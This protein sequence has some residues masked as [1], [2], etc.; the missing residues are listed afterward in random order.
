MQLLFGV[1]LDTPYQAYWTTVISC[2]KYQYYCKSLYISISTH[3]IYENK[4]VSYL[5]ILPY[6][7]IKK[8]YFQRTPYYYTLSSNS[9]QCTYTHSLIS[10]FEVSLFPIS[11]LTFFLRI[12]CLFIYLFIVIPDLLI[13]YLLIYLLFSQL[14]IRLFIFIFFYFFFIYF[15]FGDLIHD[16]ETET[17][18]WQANVSKVPEEVQELTRD[19]G[20][21]VVYRHISSTTHHPLRGLWLLYGGAKV[22]MEIKTW[23]IRSNST[24]VLPDMTAHSTLPSLGVYIYSLT[25]VQIYV[26]TRTGVLDGLTTAQHAPRCLHEQTCP[27]TTLRTLDCLKVR[28]PAMYHYSS[29]ILFSYGRKHEEKQDIL[30]SR[31]KLQIKIYVKYG[32]IYSWRSLWKQYKV[33]Q[34][35]ILQNI[36]VDTEAEDQ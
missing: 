16:T 7:I 5:Q 13:Y 34:I 24:L 35:S 20:V 27:L 2:A 11:L 23:K 32:K 12:I 29:H 31:H 6:F 17:Q 25:K 33:T 28:P 26:D 10:S 21:P 18:E 3:M 1:Q 36:Y 8:F 9:F 14:C 15:F 22:Y 4:K 30:M 19:N